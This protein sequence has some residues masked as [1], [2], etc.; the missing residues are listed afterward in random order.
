MNATINFILDNLNTALNTVLAAMLAH[1]NA[2][3]WMVAI[4]ILCGI[5]LLAN[6]GRNAVWGFMCFTV[7]VSAGTWLSWKTG[8]TG[9]LVQQVVL[10]VLGLHGL[11]R[12]RGWA[13]LFRLRA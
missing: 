13:L 6:R 3:E 8:H 9:V 7:A 10:A 11:L 2:V 12:A 1:T 4:F 5:W